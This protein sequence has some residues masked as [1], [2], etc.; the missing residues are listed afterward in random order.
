MKN[1]F[2]TKCQTLK[3]IEP[4]EPVTEFTEARYDK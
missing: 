4:N 2:Y 1:L 3:N